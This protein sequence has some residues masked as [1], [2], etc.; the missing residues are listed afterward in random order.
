MRQRTLSLADLE[1]A[2]EYSLTQV[3]RNEAA[4]RQLHPL[5]VRGRDRAVP[6]PP[7]CWFCPHL[8]ACHGSTHP[9]GQPPG[10]FAL[11]ECEAALGAPRGQLRRGLLEL[12]AQLP[13][14]T[15]A[16]LRA[17]LDPARRGLRTPPPEANIRATLSNLQRAGLVAT[18]GARPMRYA[19]T[20]AGVTQAQA[21][22]PD[23]TV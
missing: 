1:R 15:V 16:E 22:D 3:D 23:L 20:P 5:A 19:L 12:L 17:A 8:A 18:Q 11:P 13:G 21:A 9:P 2:A 4:A 14:A 10:P 7:D 6:P